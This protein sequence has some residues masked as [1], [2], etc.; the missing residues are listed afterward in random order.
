MREPWTEKYYGSGQVGE[1]NKENP[2]FFP[3]SLNM[4]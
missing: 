1:K 2:D 4:A 3:F